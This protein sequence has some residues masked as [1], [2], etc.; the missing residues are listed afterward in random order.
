MADAKYY[1]P[2][3]YAQLARFEASYWWF[4][5]RNRILLWVLTAK[6]CPFS[7]L[8]E[9]GCGTGFV[10]QA[11]R[12]EFPHS[13]LFGS[14]YF[15]E[16]LLFARERLPSATFCRMD[17]TEMDESDV[18]DVIGAFDVIEHIE[19]DLKVLSNL[20]RALK[21]GG[22]LIVTVPQ[23]P[24]LW[25]VVDEK[26]CHVRRYTR[27]ELVNK[28][29][30]AGLQVEYLTS[31]VSLLVPLLWL[32]RL[33]ARNKEYDPL[34][35]FRLPAWQNRILE[36]VMGLELILLKLGLRFPVGGSLLLVGRK[37]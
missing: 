32:S 34:D 33:R 37:E 2:N 20:V 16:G 24:L 23:H 22:H 31:F 25:S 29:R 13:E 36:A 11:I 19:M 6:I 27:L 1:S 17:A 21:S 18:Y 9:V 35:E 15:E 14:E 7:K 12:K 5:G 26:A 3:T 30:S 8:L 10:L 28:V 4:R